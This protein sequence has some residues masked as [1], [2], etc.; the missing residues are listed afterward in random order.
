MLIASLGA[1]QGHRERV[2]PITRRVTARFHKRKAEALTT[3]SPS[4]VRR[5]E[6]EERNLPIIETRSDLV[7]P[8]A[9][10]PRPTRAPAPQSIS[11]FEY[12]RDAR[13]RAEEILREHPRHEGGNGTTC[14]PCLVAYPCDA[15]RAAQDVIAISAKLHLGRPLSG[16]TLLGL[17]TD[18]VDLGA[19]D[20]V[21]EHP[22]ADPRA[23]R[24]ENGS[25]SAGLTP[26]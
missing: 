12:L 16:K 8:R 13:T 22:K 26:H 18:L 10:I 1:N 24:A 7:A 6:S 19:T 23:F 3:A 25:G 17:M 14:E 21:R 5:E 2:M 15:V 20:A 11:L 9:Q 4:G